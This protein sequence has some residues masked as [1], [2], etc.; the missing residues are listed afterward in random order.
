[1]PTTIMMTAIEDL[2]LK[3]HALKKF[4]FFYVKSEPIV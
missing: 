4:D 1:M 3:E 2:R